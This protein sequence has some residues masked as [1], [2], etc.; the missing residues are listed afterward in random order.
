[1]KTSSAFNME[2]ISAI[3]DS[4]NLFEDGICAQSPI[5]RSN[6]LTRFRMPFNEHDY[7]E[8]ISIE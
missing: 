5:C 6:S 4:I 7:S 3:K 1:M 8:G 2:Q